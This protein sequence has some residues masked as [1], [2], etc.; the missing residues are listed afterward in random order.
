MPDTRRARATFLLAFGA[1]LLMFAAVP[2]LAVA[3]VR[4]EPPVDQVTI[5]DAPPGQ[6]ED[7]VDDPAAHPGVGLKKCETP[8]NLATLIPFVGGGIL[9]LLAV[10]LGWYLV[11][12]RRASRPFLPDEAVGLGGSSGA[13]AGAGAASG[14]WW[15]CKS[16][17]ST[18]MVGVARCYKCGAWPR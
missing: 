14:E 9:V 4:L 16:C 5:A 7:C 1:A 2:S 17:G 8:F 10:A 15:T 13:V 12:R 6:Q 3:G 11:M 18:N